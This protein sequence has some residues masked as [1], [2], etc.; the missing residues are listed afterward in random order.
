MLNMFYF[1][2]YNKSTQKIPNDDLAKCMETILPY[3]NQ[4][5]FLTYTPFYPWYI[6]T[7]F[8]IW[9]QFVSMLSDAEKLH[10]AGNS[11]KTAGLPMIFLP[12]VGGSCESARG[13][14]AGVDVTRSLSSLGWLVYGHDL[15]RPTD[16]GMIGSFFFPLG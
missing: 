16:L 7:I 13:A 6:D 9:W 11:T 1:P 12:K 15:N 5:T 2:K 8:C 10:Y 4:A 3:I 14:K